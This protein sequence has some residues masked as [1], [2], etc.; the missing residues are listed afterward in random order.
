MTMPG[1]DMPAPPASASEVEYVR[2]VHSHARPEIARVKHVSL[3][4]AADFDAKT[5]TGAAALH[6]QGRRGAKGGRWR[7]WACRWRTCDSM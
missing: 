3:D 2:D 6:I 4:L 1:S 5:R 7:S